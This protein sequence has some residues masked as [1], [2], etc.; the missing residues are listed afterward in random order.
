MMLE[1]ISTACYS[2]SMYMS[3]TSSPVWKTTFPQ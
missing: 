3:Y 2:Y 1:C